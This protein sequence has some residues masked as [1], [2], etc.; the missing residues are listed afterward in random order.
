MGRDFIR[1]ESTARSRLHPRVYTIMAVLALWLAVAVWLFGTD[2]YIDYL[3]AIVSGFILVVMG[4]AYILS[5]VGT[6]DPGAKPRRDRDADV[7]RE[8]FRD[9]A[10]GEFDTWQDRV[11]ASNAAVEILLPIAALAFGMTAIGIV[12]LF[13][14]STT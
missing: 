10:L 13:V 8:S 2:S 5:R 1:Q 14:Q 7:G 3:L 12:N 11:K 4:L 6:R 9:W